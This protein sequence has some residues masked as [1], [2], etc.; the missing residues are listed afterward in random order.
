[1]NRAL[2]TVGAVLQSARALSIDRLD[3]QLLLAHVLQRP[4]A[5]LLAHEDD[6]LDTAHQTRV[7][8]LLMRRA[9]GEPLAYLVGE[10]EFHGLMLRVT[11]AVLV[12]RPD[13][14]VLVEWALELSRERS[15]PAIADLGTGSGAIALALKQACPAA[16]VCAVDASAQALNV[17]NCNGRQLGLE[18]EWSLS[19]WWSALAGRRFDIVVSNPPYIAAGDPHLN[20]L[21]HEPQQALTSGLDGLDAIRRIAH[22]APPHLQPG[23][24]L[25]LEHGHDQALA[26]AAL[27]TA[28][29]FEQVTN[30]LDLA[31]VP[32]CTGGRWMA[33]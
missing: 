21:R 28:R 2:S 11:P 8:T 25:L 23:G 7:R 24:W 18:V 6:A 12:P 32:R 30:R 13:T 5:W 29:G 3:A 27:F 33:S 26:V 4:R 14:E 15:A 19:D 10:K 22:D 16:T 31:G 9:G 17:A 20:S 1:M